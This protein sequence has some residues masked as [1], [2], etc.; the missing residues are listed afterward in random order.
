V[1]AHNPAARPDNKN[2]K[3]RQW[4]QERN[5]AEAVTQHGFKRARWRRLWRQTIQDYLIA[6]IQN[7][8]ILIRRI[9]TPLYSFYTFLKFDL[10]PQLWRHRAPNQLTNY[11]E[12]CLTA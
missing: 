3:K 6:A 2:R 5:F 7:L 4:F 8:N 10:K 11:P 1:A 9:L 12:L